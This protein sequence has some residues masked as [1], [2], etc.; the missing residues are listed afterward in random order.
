MRTLII[1]IVLLFTGVLMQAQN[2]HLEEYINQGLAN[3]L[4]LQQNRLSLCRAEHALKEAKGMFLPEATL[5]S[6]F[7]M[8]AG[9]RV[10]E[11]PVGD[12]LN[13]VY[14]T[15]NQLLEQQGEAAG[16]PTIENEE[17]KFL[18]NQEYD[19]GISVVQ[20]IY[21]RS[22]TFNKRIAEEQL[23]MTETELKLF[24]RDLVF[25]IKEAYY[26]YLKTEQ[27]IALVERTKALVYENLRVTTRMFENNMI[28]RDAVL[29][30]KSEV[31]RVELLES[32]FLKNRKIAQSYF[33]F[34][35]N[36]DMDIEIRQDSAGVS[37]PEMPESGL[38]A[39]ALN[40]REELALLKAQARIYDYMAGLNSSEMMPQV[41]LAIDAGLQ[42]EE[43]NSFREND[44]AVGSVVMSWTLF[45]G[46]VNRNKRQQ[47]LIEKQR[48]QIQYQETTHKIALEVRQDFLSIQE[49]KHNLELARARNS[50]AAEGYRIIQK[51]YAQREAPLIELLDAR[52]NM[53]ESESELINTEY[54]LY[55]SIAR[56]E[57]SST[58]GLIP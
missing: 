58:L 26:S 56:L 27:L 4:A 16:F 2:S 52:N 45:K 10:I 38:T 29:R 28:T 12:L 47:V 46:N 25:Q 44:Y 48:S 17:I 55:I 7:S 31:S 54:N 11:F 19:A 51:R 8:A 36:R 6:R 14:T 57:K 53:V 42:G 49:Q 20:P 9:G 50:E 22:L 13:P 41:A 23:S 39:E 18:R 1:T 43:F 5:E 24:E 21:S 35:I 30:A 32:T 33:N 3:N 37:W 34:L 40:N 15:L